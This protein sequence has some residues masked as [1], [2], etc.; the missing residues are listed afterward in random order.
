MRRVW[1]RAPST[2]ALA[3]QLGTPVL[4]LLGGSYIAVMAAA[5]LCLWTR[6]SLYPMVKVLC[7]R[8]L[9]LWSV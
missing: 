3:Q 7:Q 8:L 9:A 2:T 1:S 4:W 5:F 6:L